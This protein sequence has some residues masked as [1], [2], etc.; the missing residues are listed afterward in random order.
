MQ[1][2]TYRHHCVILA[3][4]RPTTHHV[5]TTSA[6]A[7]PWI[8]PQMTPDTIDLPIADPAHIEHVFYWQAT[9][10]SVARLANFLRNCNQKGRSYPASH[11][12]NYYPTHRQLARYCDCSEAAINRLANGNVESIKLYTNDILLAIAC[13]SPAPYVSSTVRFNLVTEMKARIKDADSWLALPEA[14]RGDLRDAILDGIRRRILA[15][16]HSGLKC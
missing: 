10:S 16:Q 14:C 6:K 2:D 15:A 12:W 13:I 8:N 4:A 11:P 7:S 3:A 1:S 5:N 9:E